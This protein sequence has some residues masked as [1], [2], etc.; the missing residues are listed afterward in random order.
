MTNTVFSRLNYTIPSLCLITG[1]LLAHTA[2]KYPAIATF[3]KVKSSAILLQT[4][5]INMYLSFILQM[6][7]IIYYPFMMPT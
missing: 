1:Y 2:Q 6:T 7:T 4:H 5:H 3:E